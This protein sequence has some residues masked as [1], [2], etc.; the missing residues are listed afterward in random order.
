MYRGSNKQRDTLG[1]LSAELEVHYLEEFDIPISSI[2]FAVVI[3]EI[4]EHGVRR[5]DD[6]VRSKVWLSNDSIGF[7]TASDAR[8]RSYRVLAGNHGLAAF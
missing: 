6:S 1:Q 4:D 2:A 8:K 5:V 7:I 3:P